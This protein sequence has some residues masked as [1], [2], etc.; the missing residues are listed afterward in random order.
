MIAFWAYVII[1]G[2]G[3]LLAMKKLEDSAWMG[4][5]EPMGIATFI[6]SFFISAAVFIGLVS[7]FG[8]TGPLPFLLA[9]HAFSWVK[10]GVQVV[11][12]G[13]MRYTLSGVLVSGGVAAAAIIWLILL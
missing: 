2:L 6:V 1:Q 13:G 5:K 4:F 8:F 12:T 11:K 7:H 3:F 10:A 9:W